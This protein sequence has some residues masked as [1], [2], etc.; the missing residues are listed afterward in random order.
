LG[1]REISD[2]HEV[3]YVLERREAGQGIGHVIT[4]SAR[5]LVVSQLLIASC[6]RSHYNRICF[7]ANG[8]FNNAHH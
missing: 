7:T 2:S 5:L 4:C 6:Y 3:N 8:V 1:L